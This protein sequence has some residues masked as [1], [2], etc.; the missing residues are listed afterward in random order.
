VEVGAVG[1]PA[2]YNH[3]RL[4]PDAQRLAVNTVDRRTG[5]SD[6]S[7]F[8]LPRGTFSRFTFDPGVEWFPAWSPDSRR[9]AF[10]A[11]R[12]GMPNL[13]VK[14][15]SDAAGD[16]ALVPPG[17]AVH[18]PWDW[19]QTSEGQFIVYSDRG[20]KTG[21]DLMLLPLQGA[22]TPRPLVATR[23]GETEARIS[24]DR[25]WVAYVSNE[26]RQRQ[27]YVRPFNGAG[28]PWQVSTLSGL[29][30]RW[31]DDGKELYYLSEEGTMMVADVLA[32]TTFATA[33][34]RQLFHSG[35]VRGLWGEYDVS[36]DGQRFLVNSNSGSQTEAVTVVV[37]WVAGVKQ[38]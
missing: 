2:N 21:L 35:R 31:R 6:V 1:V 9:I 30:P 4:S 8:D 19:V 38:N 27:V 14:G 23:F 18:F 25:K 12:P 22:R 37:N 36:P 32:S 10:A 15:L 13:H 17:A 5:T 33:K 34:P 26:T 28:E 3:P 11:N 29:T 7:I 24:P 20:E 16:E